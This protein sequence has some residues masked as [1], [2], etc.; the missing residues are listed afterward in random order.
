MLA[1]HQISKLEGRCVGLPEP[2]NT[3][4]PCVEDRGNDACLGSMFL[5]AR[6]LLRHNPN[7]MQAMTATTP[8]PT[9]RP[10]IAP[11]LRPAELDLWPLVF[12][13]QLDEGDEVPVIAVTADV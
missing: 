9:D 13:Q 7:V 10:A 2:D 6:Y 11:S 1:Q 4:P 5:R 8:T 3:P 12:E